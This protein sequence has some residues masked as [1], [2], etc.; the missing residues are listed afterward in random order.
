MTASEQ[1]SEW[2]TRK[3]LTDPKAAG[4]EI[5]PFGAGKALNSYRNCAI[6][7]LETTNGQSTMHSVQNGIIRLKGE[8]PALAQKLSFATTE[9]YLQNSWH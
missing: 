7:E 3:R 9:R 1:N 8:K 5:V 4:W 6:T 2:L